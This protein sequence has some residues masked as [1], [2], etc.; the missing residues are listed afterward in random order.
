MQI[1]GLSIQ[2]PQ[3]KS[4]NVMQSH[5]VILGLLFLNLSCSAQKTVKVDEVAKYF[6]IEDIY[7]N[8]YIV[9]DKDLEDL[10]EE[11]KEWVK[12]YFPQIL[13]RY[14]LT[15][16]SQ[17]SIASLLYLEGEKSYLE[18]L[19]VKHKR[20]ANNEEFKYILKLLELYEIDFK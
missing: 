7:I 12:R 19:W 20:M 15:L 8:S 4:H 14:D 2:E 18:E 5:L 13:E 11:N 6:L 10:Y 16:Y 1:M 9:A 3:I 17:F